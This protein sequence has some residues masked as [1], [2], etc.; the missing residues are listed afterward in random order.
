VRAQLLEAYRVLRL[1]HQLEFAMYKLS[2][3]DKT[4]AGLSLLALSNVAE[5]LAGATLALAKLKLVLALGCAIVRLF[6]PFEWAPIAGVSL[7]MTGVAVRVWRDGFAVEAERERYQE[8]SH[9]L[10]SLTARWESADDDEQRFR[11]AEEVER[12]A[13]EEL[14]TFIRS[15]EQAQFLF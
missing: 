7:A 10:A 8:L 12:A 3:D 2:V 15:H 14:R 6:V 9:Q 11:V 4:F 5:Q 13:L 1:D